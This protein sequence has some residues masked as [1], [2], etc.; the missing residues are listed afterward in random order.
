MYKALSRERLVFL[1]RNFLKT[2]EEDVD[3]DKEA[4]IGVGD[5]AGIKRTIGLSHTMRVLPRWSAW[6]YS[7]VPFLCSATRWLLKK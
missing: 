2:V 3:L 6:R 7:N 1:E 5:L 4:P